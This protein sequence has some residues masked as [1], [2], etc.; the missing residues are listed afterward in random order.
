M[1]NSVQL[2]LDIY[3]QT[4]G[5]IEQ[6]VA[7]IPDERMAEQHGACINHPA[8]TLAHLNCAENFLLMLLDEPSVSQDTYAAFGP[9]SIP[10]ADRAKYPG[11][12]QLA[13]DAATIRAKV[14][15]AV[16]A[17]AATYFDQPSPEKLRSFAPT[18]GNIV[19]YLLAAHGSYHLAQI[20]QWKR[21]AGL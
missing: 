7:S 3:A 10:L 21:G 15:A 13:A 19:A 9:G 16:N 14:I 2:L 12:Q 17:K 18:R 8:W 5:Y 6:A 11:K 20:A 1:T 4:H